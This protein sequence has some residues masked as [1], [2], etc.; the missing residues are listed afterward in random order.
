MAF[1]GACVIG[2]CDPGLVFTLDPKGFAPCSGAAGDH[3]IDL[4]DQRCD[5]TVGGATWDKGA[6]Q[7][8]RAGE[9]GGARLTVRDAQTGA[10]LATKDLVNG[11][12]D[13][14]RIDAKAHP[15]ITLSIAVVAKPGSS[16]WNDFIPPRVTVSWHADPQQLCFRAKTA[17]SCDVAPISLQAS[18]GPA[19]ESKQVRLLPT[20][21]PVP[22][23]QAPATPS[24][25]QPSAASDLL[26]ACSDRRVVLED[27][28]V[29]R[30]RVQLLGVADR[31]YVGQPV[32]L[33]FAPAAKVVATAVVATDGRFSATAPLP[34]R[35]LRSSAKA[36]Y[37][38]RIG[39]ES[40]LNLKL[41]RRMLVTRVSFIAGKVTIAGRVVPPLAPKATDRM[42]VLQRIVACKKVETV[43]RFKPKASGSFSVTVPS[44]AGQRAAV[45]RL[46]TRVRRTAR[47]KR[48][49]ATFTLPRA[50]DF[51]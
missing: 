20:G 50:V 19:A 41:F 51:R 46:S 44:V 31:R 30:G 43:A 32:K 22:V 13:L 3:T 27:V 5:G 23:Q 42:I 24:A 49:A 10:V 47:G 38:A 17:P 34:P 25:A 18:V 8:T 37:L 15:A 12:L 33:V 4:R 40:S 11:P 48:L 29:N 39:S 28:F 36:R 6:L 16:A 7:D 14:S 21:C 1:D 2:L 9:V 35:R 45:Y 26:L